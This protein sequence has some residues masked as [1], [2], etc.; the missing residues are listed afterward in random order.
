MAKIKWGGKI[1]KSHSTATETSVE[2]VEAA[3]RLDEVTKISLGILKHVGGGHKSIKFLPI[4]GGTKA[5]VR[6]N[7]AIQEVFIYTNEP[8]LTQQ[9]LSKGFL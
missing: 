9:K 7:G 5:I 6:G 2:V 1:T 4:T 3:N 8:V